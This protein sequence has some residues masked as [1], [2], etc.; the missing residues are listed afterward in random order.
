[1]VGVAFPDLSYYPLLLLFFLTR[2]IIR[3]GERRRAQTPAA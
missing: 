2:P 3:L 1:V